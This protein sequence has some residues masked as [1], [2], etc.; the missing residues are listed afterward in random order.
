MAKKLK[1]STDQKGALKCP[2]CGRACITLEEYANGDFLAA[3]AFGKSFEASQ[4]TGK[5]VECG[6]LLDGC[7]QAGP[8]GKNHRV[9]VGETMEDF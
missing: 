1:K 4:A 5:T 8:I 7:C 6:V 9:P 2:R 3:H